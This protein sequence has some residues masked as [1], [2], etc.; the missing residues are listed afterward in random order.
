LSHPRYRAGGSD[1]S[2]TR[3][4]R[5]PS[6]SPLAQPAPPPPIGVSGRCE[7]PALPRKE[8]PVLAGIQ[9]APTRPCGRTAAARRPDDGWLHPSP[10]GSPAGRRHPAPIGQNRRRG[11]T[12]GARANG[13]HSPEAGRVPRRAAS[14]RCL[15]N[16][17]PSPA[18]YGLSGGRPRS[19]MG[20]SSTA[21]RAAD[22]PTRAAHRL[23]AAEAHPGEQRVRMRAEYDHDPLDLGHRGLGGDRLLEQRAAPRSASGFGPLQRAG[24][25][26]QDQT[27]I[28]ATAS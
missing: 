25:R 1:R 21:P 9:L 12:P 22:S 27:C 23:G 7:S 10:S 24:A 26:R 17:S 4:G 16:V 11:T 15:R 20:E 13:W 18:V 8:E 28:Q 6:D 19:E 3:S 2:Q 14:G 5:E